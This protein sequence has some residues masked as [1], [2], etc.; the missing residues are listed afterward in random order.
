MFGTCQERNLND[1]D[2]LCQHLS[3]VTTNNKM[4]RSHNT[5]RDRS[6]F[7]KSFSIFV[8]RTDAPL[9]TERHRVR[10]KCSSVENLG[11]KMDVRPAFLFGVRLP[12]E[13]RFN[14]NLFRGQNEIQ[15]RLWNQVS[16]TFAANAETC[17]SPR[18]FCPILV[19]SITST[20]AAKQH[21]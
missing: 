1:I 11:E 21:E 12:A 3:T 14:R 19:S 4:V 13:R 8:S 18:Y 16:K 7:T 9:S 5:M 2:L 17:S 20:L 6:R 15:Q 10:P